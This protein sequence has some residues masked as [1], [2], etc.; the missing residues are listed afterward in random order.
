MSDAGLH[1]K[2]F[3]QCS[4]KTKLFLCTTSTCIFLNY[5]FPFIDNILNIPSHSTIRY[6]PLKQR[7]DVKGAVFNFK[8]NG[9]DLRVCNISSEIHVDH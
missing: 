7:T 5:F 8:E 4:L 2:K 6:G 3:V 9:C 1:Q